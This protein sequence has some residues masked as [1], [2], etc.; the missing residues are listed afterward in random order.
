MAI[1]IAETIVSAETTGGRWTTKCIS[2]P[3]GPS[4]GRQVVD[5]GKADPFMVSVLDGT[6]NASFMKWESVSLGPYAK[7][8]NA[9]ANPDLDV[10]KGLQ[11]QPK[12]LHVMDNG[13]NAHPVL[14]LNKSS[15]SS[16]RHL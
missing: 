16:R 2:T 13:K 1:V 6:D 15:A 8:V 10:S 7:L 12:E 4:F 11:T 3:T 14:S 5:G 9:N